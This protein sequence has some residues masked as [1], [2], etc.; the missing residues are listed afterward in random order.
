MKNIRVLVTE[1]HQIVLDSLSLLI[2]PF[3]KWK[4]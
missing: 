4:L 1:D 3:L 2:F